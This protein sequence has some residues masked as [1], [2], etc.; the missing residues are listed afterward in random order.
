MEAREAR[1]LTRFAE[2]AARECKTGIILVSDQQLEDLQ[3]PDREA[4]LSL[5]RA[6]HLIA[7]RK[8]CEQDPDCRDR[9]RIP[10]IASGELP[11]CAPVVPLGKLRY[12]MRARRRWLGLPSRFHLYTTLPV[13]RNGR[14][15]GL[16]I[17]QGTWTHLET[18]GLQRLLLPEIL[19]Q[20]TSL[21]C[22]GP[23]FMGAGYKKGY[24]GP[25]HRSV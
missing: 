20:R 7:L 10:A 5:S 11:A 25:N 3:D 13:W 9:H 2:Y 15:T 23:D 14:R 24:K 21:D 12:E 19:A 17:Q 22:F 18:I 8:L 16:K 1:I 6:P 4:D